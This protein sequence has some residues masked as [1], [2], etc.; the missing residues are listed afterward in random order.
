MLFLDPEKIIQLEYRYKNS[1]YYTLG[2]YPK[3]VFPRLMPK[4]EIPE[5]LYRELRLESIKKG[6][7]IEELIEKI[8]KRES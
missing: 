5:E 8:V 1:R 2:I 3:K 4:I 6:I 7:S